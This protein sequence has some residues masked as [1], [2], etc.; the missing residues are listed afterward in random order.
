MLEK[1]TVVFIVAALSML[2][3]AKR[4]KRAQRR[5][6]VIVSAGIS[7]EQLA[8]EDQ[9]NEIVSQGEAALKQGKAADAVQQYQKALDLVQHQPLLEERKLYALDKLANGYVRA[10]RAADAIP[11]YSQLLAGKK[12]D[13]ESRTT[14]VSNCADAQFNLG[15]AQLHA[16]D[17]DSALVTLQQAEG[18]YAVAEKLSA[19]SREFALIQVKNRAQ[20]SLWIAITL[21]QLGKSKEAAAVVEAAIPQLARVQSDPDI[22]VGIREDAG[23]S[24]Q[25]AQDFLKRLREQ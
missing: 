4:D 6:S 18:N 9:L 11:I 3:A 2:Q 21:F 1:H 13:C 5:D 23:R 8:L 19:D 7:K 20:T 12:D 22:N 16:H 14:A 24:L 17:F 10:G 15:M 25:D